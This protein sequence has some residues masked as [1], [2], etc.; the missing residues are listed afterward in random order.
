M[1]CTASDDAANSAKASITIVV[2]GAPD[3]LKALRTKLAKQRS[4]KALVKQANAV[5]TAIAGHRTA[6]A[7]TALTAL[8]RSVRTASARAD[9]ARIGKLM[10]C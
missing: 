2:L 3:Q 7:C 9:L 4:G 5:L 8:K 1:S 6:K 10:R